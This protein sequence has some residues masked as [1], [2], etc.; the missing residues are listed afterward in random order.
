M[1]TLDIDTIPKVKLTRQQ[2]YR[3]IPSKYPPISLFDD[4][5]DSDEFEALYELQALTNPRLLNA[6]GS[7]FTAPKRNPIWHYRLF[8]CCCTFYPCQSQW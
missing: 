4:V 5:A 2:G 1:V 6:A 7:E 8:L 3:F